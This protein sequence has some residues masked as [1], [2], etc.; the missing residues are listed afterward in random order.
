M[1][2]LFPPAE[3]FLKLWLQMLSRGRAG[4]LGGTSVLRRRYPISLEA[5]AVGANAPEGEMTDIYVRTR[6]A[7]E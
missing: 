1:L 7:I 5:P 6:E 4:G 3:S 2:P